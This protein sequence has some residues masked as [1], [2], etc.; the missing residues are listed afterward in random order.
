MKKIS[1]SEARAQYNVDPAKLEE[2]TVIEV[3]GKPVAVLVPY[4]LWQSLQASQPPRS[5]SRPPVS[6][7][8]LREVEAFERMR[9]ELMEQYRDRF[10]AIHKGKVIAVGDTSLGVLEDV[11][12]RFGRITVYIELVSPDSP[13]KARIPSVWVKR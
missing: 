10:V 6:K 8:F 4:E 3:G 13:R 12:E 1:I 5:R 9:P 11:R 2:P 7:A